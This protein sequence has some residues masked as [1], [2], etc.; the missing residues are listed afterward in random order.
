MSEL[1]KDRI[2]KGADMVPGS[3]VIKC[4]P[5]VIEAA[6]ADGDS[7]EKSLPTFSMV[8]YTGGLMDV[9]TFGWPV[10]VQ[11]NGIKTPADSV[12]VRFQHNADSGVGHTTRV[13]V[14]N[15]ELIV[16]GVISRDTEAAREIVASAAKGFPW[17]ASIGVA[18]GEVE[19]VPDDV[20]VKVNGAEFKG[21]I[22]VLTQS[23]LGE[24]SFVDLGADTNTSAEIQ[25]QCASKEQEMPDMKKLTDDKGKGVD[26]G[27]AGDPEGKVTKT[28]VADIAKVE[29]SNTSKLVTKTEK[30][31]SVEAPN[32]IEASAP[33]GAAVIKAS[34]EAAADEVLRVADVT[35]ICAAAKDS[36]L[37]AQAIREGWDKDTAELHVLRAG[38]L[39]GNERPNVANI[40]ITDDSGEENA[41]VLEAACMMGGR[42]PDL[43]KKYSEQVLSAADKRFGTGIS[44]Q[45]LLL[46]AAWA[47]GYTGR[48]FR[49]PRAI[50]EA[51]FSSTSIAGI[52]SNVANKFMLDGF[53][54]V[55]QVWREI[56]AIRSVKDF[57]QISNYRLIG[58]DQYELVGPGGEIKHGDLK[59]ETFNN[60]ADT[61]G[62]MLNIT[63]QDIIN[64]DLGALTMVP[65]KLGRGSGLKINDIFWTVFLDNSAH[66][67]SGLKNYIEG[68]AGLSVLGIDGL[69]AGELVFMDQTDLD[70]K[71]L[72][73]MPEM[74]LVP[75]ALSGT[76]NT[77]FK[78]QEIRNTTA[79]TKYPTNNV[80]NG[81]YRPVVSRYLGNSAY[82]GY[83]ATA[84]YLLGN[85]ADLA[86]IE[87]CF[88]NGQES[89]T[90][91]TTDA[92]F[93]T[94]GIQMRGYHD[95]GVALQ[96][97]KGA[98][99][100]KGAA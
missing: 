97:P 10:V 34:R 28:E 78:S 91:E 2:P 38:K 4:Q 51:A 26:Q 85:P 27:I 13:E 68:A 39:E 36:A 40:H 53:W 14:V 80:H 48:T 12:P 7:G 58:K 87:T 33:D 67:T 43:E 9:P 84:W 16:A 18:S 72:G 59:Q 62:L 88:L 76:A 83:S 81:K 90:I 64:D 61:Y 47:T 56:T 45:E 25:A 70:G 5:A 73:L 41:V 3:L 42:A 75:T 11:L 71:P 49:N 23:L 74:L 82:T 66:F 65:R 57:K 69:S 50:L 44:L 55:E 29:A 22:Y 92:N 99:K 21:P 79:S 54:S 31:D 20:R 6:H 63:R 8:A 1:V 93:D 32:L 86:T 89:P 37:T 52:L 46:E 96:D 94:L 15:G 95:F 98:L 35:K 60:Q 24:I 17:Q 77:L 30:G 100:S 19:F